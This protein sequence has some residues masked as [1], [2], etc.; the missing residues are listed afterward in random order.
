MKLT[1]IGHS[2]FK[3]EKNGYRIVID[4]YQDGSVPG[5][6]P[7]REE[8]ELVLCTH[9]H[10]DHNGR[11]CVVNHPR[12]EMP[13]Q[14]TELE[15]F[16]DAQEGRQRGL[17]HMYILDDGEQRIAHLGDIGCRLTEKQICLLSNLDVL[18]LPVGGYYTIDAKEASELVRILNPRMVIPMHFRDD[19]KGFGYD[20]I[21]TVKEFT[22]LADG[23][24]S[25]LDTSCLETVQECT[26]KTIVLKPQNCMDRS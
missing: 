16:H 3:I 5:L 4:P 21:G 13:F 7:V 24:V 17:T 11:E 6:K 20:V 10:G 9:E 1:W 8:A 26:H 22:D 14:V 19:R 23:D 18:L 2:C 25:V 12:K 15:T